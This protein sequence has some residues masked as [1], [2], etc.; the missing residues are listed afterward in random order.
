MDKL[1]GVL[2]NKSNLAD[3]NIH[4]DLFGTITNICN[5]F[6][7]TIKRRDEF[8]AP[9]TAPH[10]APQT[11]HQA[12]LSSTKQSV[13]PPSS[14]LPVPAKVEAVKVQPVIEP[15]KAALTKVLSA[16]SA[17]SAPS[18]TSVTSVTSQLQSAKSLAPTKLAAPAPAPLASASKTVA[19]P[20]APSKTVPASAPAPI[21]ASK[22]ATVDEEDQQIDLKHYN[23]LKELHRIYDLEFLI[24]VLTEIDE[25]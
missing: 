7:S 23:M 14:T 21:A 15:A 13:K 9:Q 6:A 5:T 22:T 3:T 11:T 12:S 16:S 17:P 18:V 19:P 20:P 1:F 4:K 8:N 2:I 25:L 10:A 24:E